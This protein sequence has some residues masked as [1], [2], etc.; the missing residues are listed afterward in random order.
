VKKIIEQARENDISDR[1]KRAAERCR[2]NLP[3]PQISDSIGDSQWFRDY[4]NICLGSPIGNAFLGC[5]VLGWQLHE[6]FNKSE[7]IVPKVYRA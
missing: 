7:E 1:L 2:N 4:C 5:I 6:E 3:D